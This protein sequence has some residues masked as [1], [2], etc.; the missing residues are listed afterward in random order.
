MGLL[1]DVVWNGS[2]DSAQ[3]PEFGS[4]LRQRLRP[5]VSA[6]L[7]VIDSALL[8]IFVF[9][10]LAAY[11]ANGK[12]LLKDCFNYWGKRTVLFSYLCNT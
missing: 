12:A 8:P 9:A 4:I 2:F 7:P 11:A 10:E 3:P 5:T 6:Q 1:L